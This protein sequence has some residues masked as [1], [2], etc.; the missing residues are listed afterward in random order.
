MRMDKSLNI[1]YFQNCFCFRYRC[2]QTYRSYKREIKVHLTLNLFKTV[3]VSDI[4][5][6]TRPVD[7]WLQGCLRLSKPE[8]HVRL[9]LSPF[10]TLAGRTLRRLQSLWRNVSQRNTDVRKLLVQ[11]EGWWLILCQYITVEAAKCDHW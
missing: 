6:A 11:P 8:R 7:G 5:V 2:W 4:D 3:S 1:E 10:S 9:L